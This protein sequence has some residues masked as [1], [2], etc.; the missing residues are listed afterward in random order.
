[1]SET[2]HTVFILSD[3]TGDTASRMVK[4]ALRQ[5]VGEQVAIRRFPNVLRKAEVRGILREAQKAPTFV[6]HTFA[7]TPLRNMVMQEARDIGVEAMD[8]LGPLLTSLQ[9]FLESKP[10]EEPGLLRRIDEQYF[11]RIDA[12]EF[13]V[14]HD[15]G[16]HVEGLEHADFV[17]VGLSRTGKTPL[18]V[19]L[20]LEGWR[21]G[22]VPLV[23]GLPVP[24]EVLALP[25]E[26]VIGLLVNPRR[27]AEIRRARMAY[28]APGHRMS[29][30]EEESVREEIVWCRRLF[31]EL[32]IRSVDV[33]QKAIEESA[34]QVL[35]HVNRNSTDTREPPDDEERVQKR[36]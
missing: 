1:M 14:M 8:L 20:S 19:Y 27:L 2:P 9:T 11:R 35:A 28:M 30:E 26:K 34:H 29:Y 3:S 21:V 5:F 4:A 15:D 23:Q 18:S 36:A 16:K 22:N 13:A 10:Q 31:G 25:R 33:T 6:V 7:A 12:V 24:P 32:G 17:L